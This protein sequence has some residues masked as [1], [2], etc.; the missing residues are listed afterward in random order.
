[1]SLHQITVPYKNGYDD[2]VGVD[3]ASGSPMGLVVGGNISGVANAHGGIAGYQ[4]T[5]IL[6]TSELETKL[7]ISADA[8]YGCGAFGAGVSARFS[9]AQD[10]KIQNS[11]LFMA[12]TANVELEFQSI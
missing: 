9:F 6:S 10:A 3:L 12:V 2:G 8:S 1:M 5:R 7:G 4:I 11:S